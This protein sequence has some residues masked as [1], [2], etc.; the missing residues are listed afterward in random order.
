[1]KK[2]VFVNCQN[3]T[4]SDDPFCLD[5]QIEFYTKVLKGT[6][7]NSPCNVCEGEYHHYM[8]DF[9]N[10]NEPITACKHCDVALPY[11]IFDLFETKGYLEMMK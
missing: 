5:C 1:M 11:D 9:D 2:C 10:D 4:Q 7:C 3:Q 8:P 6:S